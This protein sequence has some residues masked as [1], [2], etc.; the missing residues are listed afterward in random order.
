[1]PPSFVRGFKDLCASTL[2]PF[3][4]DA[5]PSYVLPA[6]SWDTFDELGLL[7]RYEAV[8]SSVG[9]E[10]IEKYVQAS[11]AEK[12]DT[13]MLVGLRKWMAEKIVPWMLMMYARESAGSKSPQFVIV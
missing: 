4:D 10:H 5:A 6:G 1:M 12:W 9:Y 2:P 13:S 3:D 11:C 8:I 7:D